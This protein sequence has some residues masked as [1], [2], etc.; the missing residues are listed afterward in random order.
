MN[1]AG[2]PGSRCKE[3]EGH[4]FE[5]AGNCASGVEQTGINSSADLA[6]M[7]SDCINYRSLMCCRAE[8]KK[9]GLAMSRAAKP[10]R[11]K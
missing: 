10:I 7:R 2:A 9:S 6:L 4:W 3:L 1:L 11:Y 5:L 8:R